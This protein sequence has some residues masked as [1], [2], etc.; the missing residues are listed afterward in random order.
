MA[1]DIR[2]FR[3]GDLVEV[4]RPHTQWDGQRFYVVNFIE[5]MPGVMRVGGSRL[6]IL[7]CGHPVGHDA[8]IGDVYGCESCLG[9]FVAEQYDP[10]KTEC[11]LVSA[12]ECR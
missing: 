3:L 6:R 11:R 4:V 12:S 2:K 5:S 9:M 1:A 7:N 10:F 8:V